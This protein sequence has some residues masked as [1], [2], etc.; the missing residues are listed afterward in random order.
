MSNENEYRERMARILSADSRYPPAAYD[1]VREA[2]SF[3]C[4]KLRGQGGGTGN[5]KGT[6][7]GKHISGQE[8][9]DGIRELALDE[10]GPMTIDV[11]DEW[12]IRQTGDF[13]NIVFNLVRNDL[14][15]ASEEDS[16][17]DFASGYDFVEAFVAPF[18]ETGPMPKDLPLIA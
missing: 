11:F 3:T 18:V 14:L 1:F 12:N 4:R 13:G 10:F 6:R 15:G 16:P 7:R 8:L 5:G 2:V 17:T 9:L